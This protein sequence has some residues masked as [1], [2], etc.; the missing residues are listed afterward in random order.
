MLQK[1]DGSKLIF[2][3]GFAKD[4]EC[5]RVDGASDEGPSH[6]EIQFPWTGQHR[7]RPTKVTLVMTRASRDFS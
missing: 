3:Q 2:Y 6:H 1:K 7:S 4:I 5:I